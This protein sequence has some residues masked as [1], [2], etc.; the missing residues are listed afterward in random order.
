[1]LLM[2]VLKGFTVCVLTHLD[3]KRLAEKEDWVVD[4]E[5]ITSLVRGCRLNNT[6]N[7]HKTDF[8]EKID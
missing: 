5:G 3:V 4:N 6:D 8:L 1:M 7:F 2:L